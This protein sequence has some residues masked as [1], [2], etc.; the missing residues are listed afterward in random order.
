MGKLD[1]SDS[2]QVRKIHG[3]FGEVFWKIHSEQNAFAYARPEDIGSDLIHKGV[4][5]FKKGFQRVEVRVPDSLRGLLLAILTPKSFDSNNPSYCFDFLSCAISTGE[6]DR[7][8]RDEVL[9]NKKLSDFTIV[10]VKTGEA[11]LSSTER[12]LHESCHQMGVRYSV[13]RVVDMNKPLKEWRLKKD[14]LV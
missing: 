1:F 5:R 14:D 10:E 3:D 8:G 11:E 7:L 2:K 13:H 12:Q 4:I 6:I 9:E